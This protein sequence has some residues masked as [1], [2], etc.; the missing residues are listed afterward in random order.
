MTTR[1][2]DNGDNNLRGYN[3]GPLFDISPELPLASRRS[4][5]D[6]GGTSNKS[7]VSANEVSAT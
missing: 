4:P 1:S 2:V 3:S 6:P 7:L 5:L